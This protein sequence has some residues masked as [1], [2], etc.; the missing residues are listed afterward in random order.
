VQTTE[1]QLALAR[2]QTASLAEEVEKLQAAAA[3]FRLKAEEDFLQLNATIEHERSERAMA[4][5]ALERAR[6]DHAK[7]QVPAA[8]RAPATRR[9]A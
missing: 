5:A 9:R 6:R 4:E 8:Q 1:D 2:H 7:H 3:T